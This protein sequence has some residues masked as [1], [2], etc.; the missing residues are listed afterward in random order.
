MSR[1]S[2]PPPQ[3]PCVPTFELR[4][5]CASSGSLALDVPC[6]FTAG[7]Y[8]RLVAFLA[9]ERYAVTASAV[10][11]ACL[12]GCSERELHT[13]ELLFIREL[14]TLRAR[15]AAV[16]EKVGSACAPD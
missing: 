10:A 11:A 3:V 14:G 13:A 5:E 12:A 2:L 9:K 8:E 16:P 6:S 1:R 4:L 7:R 15:G